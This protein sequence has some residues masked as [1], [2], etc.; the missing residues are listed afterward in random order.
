MLG[1][2]YVK[3]DAAARA[4]LIE[5][6]DI[7]AV[8]ACD[9]RDQMEP[10]DVRRTEIILR[11]RAV[12]DGQHR[13][14][15]ARAVVGYAEHEAPVLQQR[16]QGDRAAARVVACAVD[17]QIGERAM[18]QRTVRDELRSP[19]SLA[20]GERQCAARCPGRNQSA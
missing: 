15:I 11:L 4:A 20:D 14:R 3:R 19:G 7:C 6:G 13:V 1:G 16:G 8:R 2:G 10:Q 18:Q 12:Q 9:L 17:E 5:E